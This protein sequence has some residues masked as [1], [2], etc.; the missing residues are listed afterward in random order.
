[1][2]ATSTTPS[3]PAPATERHDEL[4]AA[5]TTTTTIATRLLEDLIRS[6][7]ELVGRHTAS[8][9]APAP[10]AEPTNLC[11]LGRRRS[12]Q[13]CPTT[14]TTTC[15]SCEGRGVIVTTHEAE[16]DTCTDAGSEVGQCALVDVLHIVLM[17][18]LL[19]WLLTSMSPLLGCSRSSAFII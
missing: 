8:L 16:D 4:P 2:A 18:G 12:P 15:P 3:A 19:I 11:C 7:I 10:A 6:N 17:L 5:A 1:M 9:P 13:A 14:T